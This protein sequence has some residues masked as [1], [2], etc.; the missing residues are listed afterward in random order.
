MGL[1][2]HGLFAQSTGHLKVG[3]LN[4][5]VKSERVARANEYCDIVLKQSPSPSLKRLIALDDG[6]VCGP[7]VAD[8]NQRHV[9]S[10]YIKAY[11]IKLK[12]LP[13]YQVVPQM[14]SNMGSRLSK[15]LDR[16]TT[17]PH[18]LGHWNV[19]TIWILLVVARVGGRL[20]IYDRGRL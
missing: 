19:G 3:R 12:M 1:T 7:E 6:V 9:T 14:E 11:A 5:L 17:R 13:G 20:T 8:V 15:D 2:Y 10:V 16:F 18:R 4:V